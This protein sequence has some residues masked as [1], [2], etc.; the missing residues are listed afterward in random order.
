[1]PHASQT[2]PSGTRAVVDSISWLQQPGQAAGTLA[3]SQ[4][5][6]R[7]QLLQRQRVTVPFVMAT[8]CCPHLHLPHA[9]CRAYPKTKEPA[10]CCSRP[11][12]RPNSPRHADEEA[13]AVAHN[14]SS[15][16]PECEKSDDVYG[17]SW[18]ASRIR[19]VLAAR[20]PEIPSSGSNAKQI[21]GRLRSRFFSCSV[22]GDDR[23]LRLAAPPVFAIA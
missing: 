9:I 14:G 2:Q 8:I 13:R 4:N 19:N 15:R 22:E 11:A 5:S 12:G 10:S 17:L 7:R 3:F 21:G 20:R 6:V 23:D 18:C 16:R 1:M